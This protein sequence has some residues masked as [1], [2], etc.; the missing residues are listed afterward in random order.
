MAHDVNIKVSNLPINATAT[1]I[2]I[3]YQVGAIPTATI[4]LAPGGPDKIKISE[5]LASFGDVDGLK[6]TA[7]VSID[8]SVRTYQGDAGYTTRKIKFSGL[9]DGLSLSN[10]VGN[11]S[12]QAVIKNNAQILLELTTITPGL[13]P[14]SINIYRNP[15]F[16][17][18]YKPESGEVD[19][20][21]TWQKFGITAEDVKK[22]PIRFY[23][24]LMQ[25]IV[26]NQLNG[27][28]KDYTGSDKMLSGSDAFTKIFSDKR[29]MASLR[30]ASDLLDKVNL[31]AVAG[32]AE[33]KVD[34]G[35]KDVLSTLRQLFIQGPT[36]VLENYMNF[37]AYMGCSL[38][39]SN[40]RLH[41]VPVNSMLK[42]DTDT[43]GYRKLQDKPNHAY[44]A[45]YNS[46][47]YNDNGYRDIGTVMVTIEGQVPGPSLGGK[48]HDTGNLAHFNA[49]K[50]LTNS[51]GVLVVNA[52]PWM[53]VAATSWSVSDAV[54]TRKDLDTVAPIVVTPFTSTKDIV[55][56]LIARRT[57]RDKENLA[58]TEKLLPADLLENYAETRFYQERYKDRTGSITMDFNPNWVPGTSGTLFVRETGLTVA[59]YVTGVNHHIEMSPPAGGSATTT[60]NFSCGRM[61]KAPHGV[62]EDKYLGYTLTKEKAVQEAFIKDNS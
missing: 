52:H 36:V 47:V 29:Y 19:A 25:L 6:R 11:N 55:D 1:G 10:L 35:H 30:I 60:I 37:L 50:D 14:T 51:A 53:V 5:G 21:L 4:T 20:A 7:L 27:S 3:Y 48:M 45:D 34:V 43:P 57:A 13:Y 58:K 59:F 31:D 32:G 56:N 18:A 42:P 49:P 8:A 54:P 12:Y 40:S 23:T 44:P 39:F 2:S 22:G 38:I 9:F 24:R 46:Y 26:T 41:V 62:S 15:N 17:I 61:G 33:E 28:W 16:S